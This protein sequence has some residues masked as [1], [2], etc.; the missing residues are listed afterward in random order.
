MSGA[1]NYGILVAAALLIAVLFAPTTTTIQSYTADAH[2]LETDDNIKIGV[3][4]D[5]SS[6]KFGRIPAG[7]TRAER[8]LTITNTGDEP[9]ELH[10][11]AAGNI[12][13]ILYVEPASTRL[14]PGETTNVT[15][16]IRRQTNTHGYYSGHV[17]IHREE[18]LWQTLW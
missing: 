10:L 3:N 1:R 8:P 15:V 7:A 13:E 17:H 9:H 14:G 4:V 12:S 11:R 16:G 18:Q 5:A 2:L 6:I